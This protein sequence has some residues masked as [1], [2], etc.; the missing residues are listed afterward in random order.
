MPL[1]AVQA[2]CL[3]QHWTKQTYSCLARYGLCPPHL[4]ITTYYLHL[5]ISD[6]QGLSETTRQSKARG[7]GD[8]L[9]GNLPREIVADQG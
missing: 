2:F 1:L 3:P 6:K 8:L 9:G 5:S 4:S 7:E